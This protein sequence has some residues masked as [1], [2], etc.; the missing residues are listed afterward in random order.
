PVPGVLQVQGDQRDHRTGGGGVEE[1]AQGALAERAAAGQRAPQQPAG[2][3]PGRVITWVPTTKAITAAVNAA[4]PARFSDGAERLSASP[5]TDV[6]MAAARP[7]AIGRE[8][9]STK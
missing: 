7:A 2:R 8:G 4:D 1:A 3:P 6:T 5:G 9:Q